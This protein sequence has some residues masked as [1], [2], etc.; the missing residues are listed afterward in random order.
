M[1]DW[2]QAS[3]IKVTPRD[4]A[5]SRTINLAIFGLAVQRQVL[6]TVDV[7]GVLEVLRELKRGAMER[8]GGTAAA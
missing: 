8:A 6:P 4:Q 2:A 7:E 3:G 5:I 1:T